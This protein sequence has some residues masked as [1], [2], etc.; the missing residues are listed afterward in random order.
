MGD[1]NTLLYNKHYEISTMRYG[2]R[3]IQWKVM[4]E[5]KNSPHPR[6]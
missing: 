3:T 2:A 6:I 5:F 4:Y 1:V